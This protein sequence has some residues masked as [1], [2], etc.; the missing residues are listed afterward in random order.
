MQPNASEQF[1][2][3]LIKALQSLVTVYGYTYKR[4]SDIT[5]RNVLGFLEDTEAQPMPWKCIWQMACV[6]SWKWYGDGSSGS[7]VVR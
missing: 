3:S 7:E 6:K 4:K 1:E 2:E 5:V